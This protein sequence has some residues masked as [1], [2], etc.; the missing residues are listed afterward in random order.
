MRRLV[1]MSLLKEV[2]GMLRGLGKSFDRV[3]VSFMGDT[4]YVEKRE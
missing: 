3:G 1:G 2:G 4:S